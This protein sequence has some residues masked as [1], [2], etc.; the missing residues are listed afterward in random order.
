[1]VAWQHQFSSVTSVICTPPY[2]TCCQYQDSISICLCT[3]RQTLLV[4]WH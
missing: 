2:E 4:W 3:R 1:M